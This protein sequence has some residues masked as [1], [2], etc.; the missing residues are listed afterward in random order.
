MRAFPRE[1]S[2]LGTMT[3]MAAQPCNWH[4]E[5]ARTNKRV[6]E[7]MEVV[8][9]MA[10]GMNII[11]EKVEAT[12]RHNAGGLQAATALRRDLSRLGST[13]YTANVAAPHAGPEGSGGQSRQGGWAVQRCCGQGP[14]RGRLLL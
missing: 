14:R 1:L 10:R 13:G 7:L 9:I 5:L 2:P 4:S 3:G 6:E 8:E 11:S 12:G